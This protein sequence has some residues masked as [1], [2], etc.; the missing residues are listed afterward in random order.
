VVV[1]VVVGW[2]LPR[3]VVGTWVVVVDGDE[4]V[5]DCGLG[6]CCRRNIFPK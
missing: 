1:M 6:L 5:E 4:R 2:Y 3:C